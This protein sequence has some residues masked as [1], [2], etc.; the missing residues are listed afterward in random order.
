MKLKKHNR[1]TYSPITERQDFTWPDGKRLAFYCALNVEHFSFGDVWLEPGAYTQSGPVMWFGGQGMNPAQVRR[2]A[3]YGSGLNPFG[4]LTNDDLAALD[5]DLG[6]DP[7]AVLIAD[8]AIDRRL[9]LNRAQPGPRLGAREVVAVERHLDELF[10]QRIRPH[11]ELAAFLS[12]NHA[13]HHIPVGEEQARLAEL[14]INH[15]ARLE[16][17]EKQIAPVE[18]RADSQQ[19][20]PDDTVRERGVVAHAMAVDALRGD[21]RGAG[22][23]VATA[24]ADFGETGFEVSELPVFYEARWWDGGQICFRAGCG[25]QT[26]APGKR[27][28]RR[29]CPHSRLDDCSA[30]RSICASGSG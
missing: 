17:V 29:F 8:A 30:K 4:P 28:A 9:L 2:I 19:L 1:Y 24:F 23:F 21:E 22:A 26:R 3:R 11:E 7:V 14:L 25:S 16:D 10:L 6:I 5:I 27:G 15:R 13:R 20:R 12:L 18:A